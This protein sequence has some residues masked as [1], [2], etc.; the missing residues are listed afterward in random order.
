MTVEVNA[1][2][3]VVELPRLAQNEE[4]QRTGG[5]ARCG[6]G[7]GE[8]EMAVKG[9]AKLRPLAKAPGAQFEISIDGTPRT[10]RD[11][12]AFAIEAAER[13]K[14]KHPNSDIVVRDLQSGEANGAGAHIS[15]SAS[16][17]GLPMARALSRRSSGGT[18]SNPPLYP[19]QGYPSRIKLGVPKISRTKNPEGQGFAIALL[20]KA[21]Q[22]IPFSR[23]RSLWQR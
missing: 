9:A 8:G 14:R 19:V 16:T 20:A 3:T 7:L 21:S 5:E 13:L 2:K 23:R 6:G 15:L 17:C 12:K 4:R 22:P 18:L 1:I 11:R 10:Y